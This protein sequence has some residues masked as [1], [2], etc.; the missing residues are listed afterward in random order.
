[1]ADQQV[2]YYSVEGIVMYFLP[3][4]VM[5]I[6]YTII[7]VKL[8]TRKAPGILITSTAFAQEKAKRKVF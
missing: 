7:G 1:M 5:I 4:L 3:V 6:A 2:A 8:L